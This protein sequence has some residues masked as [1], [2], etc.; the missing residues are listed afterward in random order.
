MDIN[1]YEILKVCKNLGVQ[2]RVEELCIAAGVLVALRPHNIL[3]IGVYGGGS[4]ALWCSLAS[5][6]KI[7]VDSGSI[8]GPIPQR[9]GDFRSWF[10]DVSVIRGNSHDEETKRQVVQ[11]LGAE[12]LDFLFIDGDHTLEGVSKDYEMYGPLVRPGGWI[13]F[14]DITESEYHKGMNAGGAAQHWTALCHPRKVHA[15][16]QDPGFGIGLVQ[17]L[18]DQP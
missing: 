2:Q 10:G 5:G 12:K 15:N 14:H 11:M 6:K 9:V 16:W 7:G 17:V 13:G 1:L 8:D 4:F 3:E 18:G